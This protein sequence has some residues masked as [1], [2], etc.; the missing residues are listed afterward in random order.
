MASDG[1]RGATALARHFLR[2][3]VREGDRVVDATCGN[4]HDTL[5]LAELVGPAGKVWGFDIQE[6]AIA[7]ASLLLEGAGCRERVELLH[8]G[9][10]Q[11]A[12]FVTGPVDA[13]VFNLGY[14]PGGE[15]GCVT[16]PPQTVAA[17]AQAVELLVPGGRICISL[18]TGHPG[19]MEE[20]KAVES[21]AAGLPP[22]EFHVWCSRQMNRSPAAPYLI[23]VEKA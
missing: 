4:G 10:E 23:M 19:G 8:V 18:Y 14:L 13:V 22:K 6:Q 17:L 1:L 3:V 20:A 2:E 21:W 7:A 5:L 9:H 15:K 16:S 11:L 12:T